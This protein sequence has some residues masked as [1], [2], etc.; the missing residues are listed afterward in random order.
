MDKAKQNIKKSIMYA[1]GG[2]FLASIVFLIYYTQSQNIWILVAACLMMTA[3]IAF[4]FFAKKF[5]KK[6]NS[7][8]NSELTDSSNQ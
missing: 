4:V 2:N 6:I 8:E 5:L 1:S 7:I 3:G